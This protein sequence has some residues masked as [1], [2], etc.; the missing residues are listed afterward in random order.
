MLKHLPLSRGE[1]RQAWEAKGKQKKNPLSR[2]EFPK[3]MTLPMGV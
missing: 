2:G 3:G 1:K